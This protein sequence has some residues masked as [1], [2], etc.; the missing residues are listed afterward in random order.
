MGLLPDGTTAIS[1]GPTPVTY[2]PA[3]P[4]G[5]AGPWRER[6]FITL[7]AGAALG[8]FAQIGLVAQLFSLLVPALGEAGAGIT[9]GLATACAIG[10]RTVLGI[11]MRP[12]TGRRTVAATNVGVQACGSIVLLVAAGHSVPLL[13]IGC[14][15][16]G[17]GPATSRRCHPWSP[18]PEFTPNDVPRV[19]GYVTAISQAGYAFAPL[20][21]GGLRDA[22]LGWASPGTDRR[23]C[24]SA[25]LRSSRSRRQESSSSV[26]RDPE[27]F[28][29]RRSVAVSVRLSFRHA[30]VARPGINRCAPRRPQSS[31]HPRRATRR[32]SA[33]GDRTGSAPVWRHQ[34]QANISPSWSAAGFVRSTLAPCPRSRCWRRCSL[35]RWRLAYSSRT[36]SATGAFQGCC[37][38]GW[39]FNRL[40]P[41]EAEL[42]RH[43]NISGRKPAASPRDSS[44]ARGFV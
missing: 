5:P 22:D 21:F 44:M 8:L 36:H 20:A 16:F 29:A 32:S 30:P 10:G 40:T 41:L 43:A 34:R 24:C 6:R 7:V 18:R 19:V 2:V 28:G 37:G 4:I 27:R 17:L 25:R 11:I 38:D 35:R 42:F 12:E 23:H 9:M 33:D 31:R 15:L 3:Q 39:F 1:D 26:G 13:L 14:V